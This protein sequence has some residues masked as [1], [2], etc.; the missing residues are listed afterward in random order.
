MM[1]LKTFCSAVSAISTT[2]YSRLIILI[3]KPNIKKCLS[4]C[5]RLL[6]SHDQYQFEPECMFV[7]QVLNAKSM[8]RK[9]H[10]LPQG[11]NRGDLWSVNQWACDET[12]HW[13][14]N[15]P[16]STFNSYKSLVKQNHDN[17]FFPHLWDA[18]QV[19]F[20]SWEDPCSIKSREVEHLKWI[21][22]WE[23][24]P[25]SMSGWHQN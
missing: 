22:I 1:F 2:S 18:Y 4:S 16:V 9:S 14:R 8:Q 20:P 15:L 7:Q 13:C 3:Q 12:C 10:W 25:T 24:K 21:S 11:H 6:R 23:V 5:L 19:R 17:R